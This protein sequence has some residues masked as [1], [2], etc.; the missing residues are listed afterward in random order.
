MEQ[1][2][3]VSKPKI[4]FTGKIIAQAK[5]FAELRIMWELEDICDVWAVAVGG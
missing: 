2:V 1:R 5:R 3:A 4:I